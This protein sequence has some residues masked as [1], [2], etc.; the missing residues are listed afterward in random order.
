MGKRKENGITL[1]ALVIT[2][3][4]LLILA[5]ITINSLTGSRLFEKTKLAKEKTKNEEKLQNQTLSEYENKIGKYIDGNTRENNSSSKRTILFDGEAEGSEG[6]IV[7]AGTTDGTS[8]RIFL[9]NVSD[10]D[11]VVVYYGCIGSDM[12]FPPNMIDQMYFNKSIMHYLGGL[13][14][15]ASEAA[16]RVKI[17][18]ENNK[19]IF[20]NKGYS[21]QQILSVIGYKF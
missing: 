11:I 3:I 17:D 19:I 9:D 6:P 21:T 15:S 4:I 5:G 7:N 18:T 8:E 16:A 10:Y 14:S 1:V 2:I 12:I 20:E 13:S